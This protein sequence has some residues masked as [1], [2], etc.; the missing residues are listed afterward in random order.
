MLFRSYEKAKQVADEFGWE[1][2]QI[3]PRLLVRC[4]DYQRQVITAALKKEGSK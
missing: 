1:V 3:G 4:S 2:H